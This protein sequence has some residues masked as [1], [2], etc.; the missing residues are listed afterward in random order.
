MTDFV[1][2]YV[3]LFWK[4]TNI[5]RNLIEET[6]KTEREQKKMSTKHKFSF[7]DYII[8]KLPEI[9]IT[10]YSYCGPNTNLDS[11]FAFNEFGI[12]ELDFACMEHDIAYVE[13]KDLE[14]RCN[15]D[16]LLVLKAIRR[17]YAKDSKIGERFAA[18]LV[19]WLISIKMFLGKIEIYIISVRN[20]I[21]SKTKK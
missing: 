7:I 15:A 17:V 2:K 14:S 9:H 20:W 1:Y 18:L 21:A 11:N 19:S 8:A 4:F 10:G 13:S 5:P 6:L 3:N 16:K 12:N